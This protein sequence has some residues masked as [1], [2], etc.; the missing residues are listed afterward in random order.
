MDCTRFPG[1]DLGLIRCIGSSFD[2][3]RQMLQVQ[4]PENGAGK[5]R[6]TRGPKSKVRVTCG[7]FLELQS[8]RG[9]NV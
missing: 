2:E 5:L 4:G 6:L 9:V 8:S 1:G 7:A 3:P